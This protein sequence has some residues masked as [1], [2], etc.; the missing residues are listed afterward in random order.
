MLRL[1]HGERGFAQCKGLNRIAAV[2]DG[3]VTRNGPCV[4]ST[5]DGTISLWASALRIPLG[6]SRADD[7]STDLAIGELY[8]DC[9]V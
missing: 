2:T 6:T 4:L 5:G 3:S 1:A 7:S 8:I 9:P